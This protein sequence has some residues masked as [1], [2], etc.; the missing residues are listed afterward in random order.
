MSGHSPAIRGSV[1]SL[2]VLAAG[3][4]GVTAPDFH[5]GGYP[6]T[7]G[8]QERADAERRAGAERAIARAKAKQERRRLRNLALSELNNRT[9]PYVAAGRLRCLI[10][11]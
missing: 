10:P 2:A 1:L 4:G 6:R 8:D 3:F 11:P 7:P 9:S 5:G